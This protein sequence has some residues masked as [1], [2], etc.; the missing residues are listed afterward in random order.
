MLI[1]IAWRACSPRTFTCTR[2]ACV[3]CRYSPSLRE[4]PFS[5]LFFFC[6][7]LSPILLGDSCAPRLC[8]CGSQSRRSLSLLFFSFFFSSFFS[9][10]TP[11][12]LTSNVEQAPRRRYWL[13]G[14]ANA[15][16]DS[17]T[18]KFYCRLPRDGNFPPPPSSSSSSQRRHDGEKFWG[19]KRDAPRRAIG[20][21]AL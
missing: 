2:P 13:S 18:T 7:L 4:F 15:R 14:H 19:M 8:L 11:Y 10:Y 6:F 12:V 9:S 5:F 21:A 20:I 3:A 17:L 16:P 1:C